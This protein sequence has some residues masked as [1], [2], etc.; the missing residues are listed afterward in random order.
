VSRDRGGSWGYYDVPME[1]GTRIYICD[2]NYVA[3][4]KYHVLRSFD[5]GRSWSIA[6]SGVTETYF[7][8]SHIFNDVSGV[9]L[10]GNSV[11]RLSKQRRWELRSNGI[12][13][14][15]ILSMGRH[16]SMLF[17]GGT[18]G[19]YR[20][21]DNGETWAEL[22][23]IPGPGVQYS[24][25]RGLAFDD[26]LSYAMPNTVIRSKDDFRT[27]DEVGTPVFERPVWQY[28][29]SF[30][31][32][33]YCDATLAWG[34]SVFVGT[35][36]SG[37]VRSLDRCRTWTE[38]TGMRA[39]AVP[40]LF[41]IPGRL[42]IG[43]NGG[44][45]ALDSTSGA[46]SQI[47]LKFPG[48]RV[49][50]FAAVGDTLY[51]CT[52][53]DIGSYANGMN[54]FRS[55]NGGSAWSNITP[56]LQYGT[57]PIQLLSASHGWIYLNV[58]TRYN[59]ILRS[60][61]GGVTWE[62]AEYYGVLYNP[63]T[64][65][66]ALATD[67]GIIVGDYYGILYQRWNTSEWREMY[68]V[69]TYNYLYVKGLASRGK[70]I[71]AWLDARILYSP[72]FGKN[73][74]VIDSTLNFD[75]TAIACDQKYV[76][77]GTGNNGL[78]ISADSGKTWMHTPGGRIYSLT[79]IDEGLLILGVGGIQSVMLGNWKYSDLNSLVPV[80]QTAFGSVGEDILLYND[81]TMYLAGAGGTWKRPRMYFTDVDNISLATLPQV[82]ELY[83]NFPNPFNPTTSITY[84]IPSSTT[85]SIVVYDLL[86]REVATLVNEHK[87]AGTHQVQFHAEGLATGVYLYRMQAGSFVE[88]K[89]LVV[90]K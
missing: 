23:L 76:Y 34:G 72:D 31:F 61:N 87:S 63:P 11:Y 6:D 51:A 77:L 37:L 27:Y 67:S 82:A 49:G 55:D 78:Y 30:D 70:E 21:S 19:L 54:L 84:Q 46:L 33:P 65:F 3:L 13:S 71:F 29:P 64:V 83:Q 18:T 89:K 59:D 40:V 58:K 16:G 25:F 28:A 9:F 39:A 43:T 14:D 44:L 17:A 74:R 15:P 42:L 50:S 80:G 35:W 5:K 12:T 7:G 56:T 8:D 24:H 53:W 86:G 73:W 60:S 32:Y 66:T 81:R 88:V 62:S 45:Y 68:R 4:M 10:F 85:V 57:P 52:G 90:L 36:T 75:V 26:S 79:P 2:T 47:E 38:V 22:T 20:S 1:V 48:A 69:G 41:P